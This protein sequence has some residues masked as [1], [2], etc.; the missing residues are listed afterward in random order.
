MKITAK[1]DFQEATKDIENISVKQ[2]PFAIS[3]GINDTAFQG[4]RNMRSKLPH[5]FNLRSKGVVNSIRVQKS[6]KK[7]TKI[8]AYVYTKDDYLAKQEFGTTQRYGKPRST[9]TTK[10]RGKSARVRSRNYA[11]S[12]LAGYKGEREAGKL[13]GRGKRRKGRTKYFSYKGFK[14]ATGYG[15][16]GRREN[17]HKK[18]NRQLF[19]A[20]DYEKKQDFK[21][22]MGFNQTIVVTTQRHG[23]KNIRNR[24]NS[25]LS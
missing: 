14:S 24:I 25:I 17:R 12:I 19:F 3:T 23:P 21:K 11:S 5:V 7:Q 18:N 9:K 20:F 22:R 10:Y 2:L 6:N 4:M 15:F 13:G 1:I 8:K 16:I